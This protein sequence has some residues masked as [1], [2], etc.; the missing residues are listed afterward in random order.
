[1]EH[2]QDFKVGVVVGIIIGVFIGFT[3]TVILF[4]LG[5]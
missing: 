3:S 1:M 2:D 5:G 4:R